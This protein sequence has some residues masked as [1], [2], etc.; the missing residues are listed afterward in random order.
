MDDRLEPGT[1]VRLLSGVTGV[2]VED[3]GGIHMVLVRTVDGELV[4]ATRAGL[5]A[6]ALRAGQPQ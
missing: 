1:E 5:A 4:R 3:L 2:V 6:A